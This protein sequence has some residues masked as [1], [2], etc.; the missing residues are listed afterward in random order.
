MLFG[1]F[2]FIAGLFFSP[3]LQ[4]IGMAIFGLNSLRNLGKVNIV[5]NLKSQPQIILCII[6]LIVSILSMFY[7]DDFKLY[8]QKIVVKIP[9]IAFPLAMG[10][11]ESIS[12]KNINL[13]FGCF[14]LC[15]TLCGAIS[16][17][18][19]LLHFTEINASIHESKPIPILYSKLNHI[20][21]GVMLAFSFILNIYMLFIN[22]ERADYGR[23]FL[24]IM[25]WI[26]LLLQFIFLH[27]IVSRT[28]IAG[29][30]MTGLIVIIAYS[31]QNRRFLLPALSLVLLA[32]LLI[33]GTI[34]YVPSWERR[35]ENTKKDLQ[36]LGNP[37]EMNNQSISMRYEALQI[38]MVVLKKNLPWG[39]GEGDLVK[40][41]RA[42]YDLS[43]SRM[44][45]ENKSL[46]HNQFVQEICTTGIMGLFCLS[47][48]FVYPFF[49]RELRSNFLLIFCIILTGIA[50]M[51]ESVLE[52]QVG[53]NFFFFFYAILSVRLD[54]SKV[55]SAQIFSNNR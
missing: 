16:F 43:H 33:V 24:K 23:P 18:N 53:I 28:G 26:C 34:R 35:V 42:Q 30:Y 41:M 6:S 44:L 21:F 45:E 5:E 46:P 12:R 32:A 50:C 51:A 17:G 31:I 39:V 37:A 29:F 19:Y 27:S 47:A 2:V 4:T 25:L 9:F 52:R 1:A 14:I 8:G 11:Y 10:F 15:S 54:R 38:A 36:A 40:E 20:Y 49:R 7:V 13:I 55:L 22:K 3:F 48:I